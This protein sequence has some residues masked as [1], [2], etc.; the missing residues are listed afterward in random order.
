[1]QTR[2]LRMRHGI[3]PRAPDRYVQ[4][5]KSKCLVSKS[6]TDRSGYPKLDLLQK[7]SSA[8]NC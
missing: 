7:E 5:P 4:S 3:I 2:D 1:M 8:T 6:A